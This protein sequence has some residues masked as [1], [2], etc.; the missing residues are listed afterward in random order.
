MKKCMKKLNILLII[1]TIFILSCS[2]QASA[3]PNYQ[4]LYGNLLKKNKIIEYDTD[5]RRSVYRPKYFLLLD[6]DRN[7]VKELIVAP[8]RGVAGEW[9]IYTIKNNKVKFLYNRF[10][11]GSCTFL[12][13]KS[14]KGIW[15]EWSEGTGLLTQA[16]YQIKNGKFVKKIE[17]NRTWHYGEK[18]YYS[19]NRKGCSKSTYNKYLNK[20]FR[21]K[22]YQAYSNI[23]NN[24]ANRRKYL[25]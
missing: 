19:V 3:K 20:Y 17:L 12:W 8:N 9:H 16:F 21:I 10:W 6:I 5:G 14:L 1:T 7:G 2:I 23:S 15:R 18:A 25:K 22:K 11:M 24:A 13:S 4:K